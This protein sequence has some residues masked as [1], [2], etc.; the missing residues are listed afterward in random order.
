MNNT[1]FALLE[2]KQLVFFTAEHILFQVFLEK[3]PQTF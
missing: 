3:P 1:L 2:F